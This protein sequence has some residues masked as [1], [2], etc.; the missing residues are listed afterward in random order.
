MISE[1]L[2]FCVLPIFV[3]ENSNIINSDE[4]CNISIFIIVG[5]SVEQFFFIIQS[6]GKSLT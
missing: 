5:E 2:A 3:G 6:S 1:M 4:I